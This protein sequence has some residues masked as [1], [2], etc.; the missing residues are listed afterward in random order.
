M[1]RS[2]MA[3]DEASM[4]K[5]NPGLGTICRPGYVRE[6][7]ATAKAMPSELNDVL[8]L[9]LCMWTESNRSWANMAA[10]STACH[11]PNLRLEDCAGRSA[12]VAMDAANKV[13]CTSLVALFE[14]EPGSG[15]LDPAALD[16]AAQTA[17]AAAVGESI[18]GADT[19]ADRIRALA[20]AGY[21][22]FHRCFVPRA[23]V[24]NSTAAN[25]ELYSKWARAGKLIVTEGARTDFGRIMQELAAWRALFPIRRFS[26][27][28]REMS[29]FVQVLQMEP[30]CDFPLVEVLQ[31]PQMI[32]QPMKELEALINCG[33]IGHDGDEVLAW[34]LGNVIQ[35]TAQ[36]GG[37][38]KYYFP[39]READENKIDGAAALIMA[40][41]GLLRQ[42]APAGEAGVVF[43]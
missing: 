7:V 40:L 39:G 10:W 28:P 13:D 23:M 33:L 26:F 24:E 32:S 29:Y 8:Q 4:I 21:V 18:Q 1:Y 3:I 19:L 15:R 20:A 22:C 34:M 12:S 42:E 31:S 9:N 30:W 14:A 41:D 35:K 11:R 17:L 16:L 5:D 27:D 25:F 2:M 6:R 38:R 37:P 36:G 43:V